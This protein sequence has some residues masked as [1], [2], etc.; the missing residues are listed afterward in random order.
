MLFLCHDGQKSLKPEARVHLSSLTLFFGY[1]VTV[2]RKWTNTRIFMH[3]NRWFYFIFSSLGCIYFSSWTALTSFSI[4]LVT[5]YKNWHISFIPEAQLSSPL[6]WVH[7]YLWTCDKWPC[8][9]LIMSRAFII[10]RMMEF[11]KCFFCI[12]WDEH[13]LYHVYWLVQLK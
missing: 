4:M 7:C 12:C 6:H 13:M 10:E 9:Y 11:V 8:F 5:S 3:F 1:F 2:M